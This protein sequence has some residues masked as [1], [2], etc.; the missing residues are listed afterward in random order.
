MT[1]TSF[2]TWTSVCGKHKTEARLVYVSEDCK[3]ITL[4]KNDGKE[5]NVA[6][7][8]LSKKDQKF[9]QEKRMVLFNLPMYGSLV[10]VIPNNKVPEDVSLSTFT[11]TSQV[12]VKQK[13]QAEHER[14]EL[15]VQ[16][17]R[18]EQERQAAVARAERERKEREAHETAEKS[19]RERI[20]A[21]ER[22]E[23]EA[24]ERAER[25]KQQSTA[26]AER[27]RQERLPKTKGKRLA[28]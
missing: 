7:E 20:V 2:R 24:A 13:V 27:E 12:A 6:L 16:E 22:R 28:G 4:L 19:E 3:T 8:K 14:H 18:A 1:N 21:Q 5:N 10:S 23:R 26:K 15:L 25:E 9:V 17:R 11:E